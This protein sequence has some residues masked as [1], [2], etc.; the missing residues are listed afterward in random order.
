MM[1][2]LT[3]RIKDNNLQVKVLRTVSRNR[4]PE[5]MA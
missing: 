1:R 5:N 4:Q 2:G 3:K